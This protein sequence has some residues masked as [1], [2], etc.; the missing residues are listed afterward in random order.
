MTDQE[1]RGV[2]SPTRIVAALR[3][4]IA[5]LDRRVPRVERTGETRIAR[6]AAMLRSQAVMRIQEL[7]QAG[8]DDHPYDQGHDTS[9]PTV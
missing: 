2:S 3:E 5:A 7:K 8:S 4:L 1:S 6:D 9:S